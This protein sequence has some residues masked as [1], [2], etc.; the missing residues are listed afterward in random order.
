[1]LRVEDLAIE[2]LRGQQVAPLAGPLVMEQITSQQHEIHISL[3]GYLKAFLKRMERVCS[4]DS[5]L[6]PVS[7]VII[8]RYQYLEDICFFLL[9]Q[10]AICQ[11]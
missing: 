11:H 3:I 10:A 4:N 8:S 5:I 6:F 1:M 9:L 2:Y 7:H